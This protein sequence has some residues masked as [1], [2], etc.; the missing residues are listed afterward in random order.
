MEIGEKKILK[1]K[2]GGKNYDQDSV[3]V[4]HF[5]FFSPFIKKSLII[6]QN[7]DLIL[8]VFFYV[9]HFQKTFFSDCVKLSGIKILDEHVIVM[10]KS[11][12]QNQ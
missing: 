12:T 9:F 1:W 7:N 4:F 11:R 3:I 6:L 5:S 2:S 10:Y 8:E